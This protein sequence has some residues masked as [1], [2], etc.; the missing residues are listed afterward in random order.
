MALAVST[1]HSARS[2]SA[3]TRASCERSVADSMAFLAAVPSGLRATPSTQPRSR[4]RPSAASMASGVKP[5]VREYSP[6]G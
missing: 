1:A 6:T 5:R 3:A 2:A 4:S